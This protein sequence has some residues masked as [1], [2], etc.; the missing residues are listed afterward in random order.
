[1]YSPSPE[2]Q[3]RFHGVLSKYKVVQSNEEVCCTH[4]KFKSFFFFFLLVGDCCS[5][6]RYSN[7]SHWNYLNLYICSYH[8]YSLYTLYIIPVYH[9]KSL[10]HLFTRSCSFCMGSGSPSLPQVRISRPSYTLMIRSAVFMR[11][12][13]A[14]GETTITADWK[15]LQTTLILISVMTISYLP[16]RANSIDLMAVVLLVPVVTRNDATRSWVS[17]FRTRICI[18]KTRDKEWGGH[19]WLLLNWKLKKYFK[20]NLAQT[21]PP[22]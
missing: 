1:M 21:I 8:L 17:V 3:H 7:I 15:D 6:L 16:L 4:S 14:R 9:Q 13:L 5:L 18:E 22:Q 12:Q 2:K 10:P 20:K 19:G 11:K